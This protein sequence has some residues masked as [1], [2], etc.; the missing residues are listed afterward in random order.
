MAHTADFDLKAWRKS[1]KMTAAQLAE[2]ITC[3]VTTIYRYENKSITPSPDTMYAICQALG[4]VS[5]WQ[6]WMRSEYYA[7]AVM[8]PK[9]AQSELAD[10]IDTFV[11]TAQHIL[12]L[13]THH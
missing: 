2:K 10:K 8:H 1:Q 5:R 9:S 11:E 7:Y 4:D 3:D 12:A 13:I 6:D